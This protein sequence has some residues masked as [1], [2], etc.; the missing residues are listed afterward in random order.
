[1]ATPKP[2][3]IPLAA[4]AS[5]PQV[6]T[7]KGALPAE[8]L[9]QP[10][11]PP[12]AP[13]AP[14]PI[15]P[16]GAAEDDDPSSRLGDVI[17]R[18]LNYA[19]GQATLGISPATLAEAYFDWL[20]HL[21]AAPGKQVQLWH[22]ALR[23]A[24][25][26]AHY[27]GHCALE[28]GDGRVC[29]EPLEQ[30]KR[31][32][33]EAWHHWPFNVIH[34]AFLLQQQW[35]H[36]AT[37]D[38]R[39]VTTQ[40]ERQVEFAARQILD[41]LSP[42]NFLATN[43]EV[44]ERTRSEMGLNLFRG[45]LNF[46]EDFERGMNGRPPAGADRFKVGENLALTP[47]KVVFR[48]RLI[49]LI[50]YAPATGEVRPEP[51]LIVPSWIMKFYILDLAPGRSLVEHLVGA[52][53]TVFIISW[54]NPDSGDRDLGLDDYRTLGIEAALDAIHKICPGEEVHGCGYCL[55]GTLLA[56]SAAVHAGNTHRVFK[57]VSLLAAEV[58]FEE[59]GEIRLFVNESQIS[60]LEDMMWQQ[61][62]LDGPQM[63]GAFQ[64]LRSKDLVW[65]R[66]VHDYLMGER[67]EI[68]DLMAWN[69]D[70]T[71]MPYRM[72]SEYLRRMFLDND[73]AAGRY[74]VGGRKVAL[75]DIRAPVFAVG[76]E[77][78]H[79]APWHSVYKLNLLL[80][81]DV[82]F[83]LTS[84]GHNA[85][86]VSEVKGSKHRY[87]VA[88]RR[89]QDL[90]TDPEVWKAETPA[91]PGSWWPE[92]VRWLDASSGAPVTPP[93]MGA[94]EKGMAPLADAPGTYVMQR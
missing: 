86:I 72:H 29:I 50:Q 1:M 70:T 93:R 30:D 65:S 44:I 80:D 11:P 68:F 60:F 4:P 92:W 27:M 39:G 38:V 87:R 58:D 32:A 67:S 55:G 2:V 89:D 12:V 36:N 71:R 77:T 49:E 3:A 94:P 54:K 85:G 62:Y 40:H 47:G 51:V 17:D 82:T 5:T 43:P 91:K 57:T 20:I 25:R 75:T 88:T 83:L 56:I 23:K 10:S 24:M 16:A 79:V 7:C 81:T 64:M 48:N 90:Y 41:L 13:P 46:V 35:W 84:G 21:S 26:L 15:S 6:V 59:A 8:M 9:R 73:L 19:V 63:A 52:G 69:A 14:S 33:G 18:S 53:Y 31:F 22:K 61:G 37:T 74:E 45:W 42:S 34:Q 76:T 66:V 78:D 28:G